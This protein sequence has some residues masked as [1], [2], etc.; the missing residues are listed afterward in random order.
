LYASCEITIS[1]SGRTVEEVA[2]A[3]AAEFA[4]VEKLPQR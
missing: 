3:I 1:T 4:L 2:A